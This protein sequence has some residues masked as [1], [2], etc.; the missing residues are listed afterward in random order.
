MTLFI[1]LQSFQSLKDSFPVSQQLICSS[2]CVFPLYKCC[3]LL[4]MQI[5]PVKYLQVKLRTL[6]KKL[7]LIGGQDLELKQMS[8]VAAAEWVAIFFLF[9]RSNTSLR[10]AGPTQL[11]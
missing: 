4:R 7:H 6:R 8:V 9:S 10:E 5:R 2:V 11:S 3:M 1:V